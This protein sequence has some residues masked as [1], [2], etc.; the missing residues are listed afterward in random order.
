MHFWITGNTN[1]NSHAK[2]EFLLP[3]L[4]RNVLFLDSARTMRKTSFTYWCELHHEKS[5]VVCAWL[6]TTMRRMNFGVLV[7]FFGL[8]DSRSDAHWLHRNLFLCVSL[9]VVSCGGFGVVKKPP[10]GS[11]QFSLV[12]LAV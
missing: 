3:A 11:F 10:A 6:K 5:V 4:L 7:T 8:V 9:A 1:S 2:S 12:T